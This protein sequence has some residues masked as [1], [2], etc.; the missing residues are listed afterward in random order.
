MDMMNENFP[1]NGNE[2]MNEGL[3]MPMNGNS[4][5][6]I[7]MLMD[8]PLH[9]TVE[10]GRTKMLLHQALELQ[11]GSVIELDR[12]AGDPIDVFINDRLIAR[13]EVVVVDDKFAVRITE[14]M[15]SKAAKE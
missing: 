13:G 7:D 15:T 8:V 5:A 10:L 12:M 6:N 2:M 14:L 9:I 1:M 4:K 11:S 3:S